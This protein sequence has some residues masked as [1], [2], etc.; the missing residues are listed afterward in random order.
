MTYSSDVIWLGIYKIISSLTAL[1]LPPLCCVS[2]YSTVACAVTEEGH[3]GLYRGVLVFPKES[4]SRH[5]KAK[6]F[7]ETPQ[8]SQVWLLQGV[9]LQLCR[10]APLAS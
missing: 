10:K 8:R 5:R 2:S 9:L 7:T 1:L 3:S 4:T 6:H